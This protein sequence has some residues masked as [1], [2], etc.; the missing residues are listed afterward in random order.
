MHLSG[1]DGSNHKPEAE[2]QRKTE[3]NKEKHMN[4]RQKKTK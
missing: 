3:A 1:M 4:K 2:K